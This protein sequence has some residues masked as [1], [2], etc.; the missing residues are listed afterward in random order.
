MLRLVAQPR[1][2]KRVTD[3]GTSM[4]FHYL[5]DN[6][7]DLARAVSLTIPASLIVPDAQ[8]MLGRGGV[9]AVLGAIYDR[10]LAH[11][12]H[13]ALDPV[14]ING[15]PGQ[16]VRSVAEVL[17]YQ[18]G[19]CLDLALLFAS[20]CLAHPLVPVVILFRAT[21]A[22]PAHA[23]LAVAAFEYGPRGYRRQPGATLFT[24]GYL[25]RAEALDDLLSAGYELLEPTGVTPGSGDV[26]SAGAG[27]GTTQRRLS[28]AEAFIA[29]QAHLH[30]PRPFRCALDIRTLCREGYGPNPLVESTIPVHLD[31]SAL[32]EQDLD[33][34]HDLLVRSYSADE[35]RRLCRYHFR[36]VMAN[37]GS[38][39]SPNGIAEQ[40]ILYC[41]AQ[42]QISRLLARVA[43]DNPAQWARYQSRHGT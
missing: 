24:R 10:V 7:R 27:I 43:A 13:Y 15:E 20:V 32:D 34:I 16:P 25:E 42:R 17:T 30:G 6:P 36:P 21:S 11:Q 37:L 4:R 9:R 1:V 38:D 26:A 39:A 23:I 5:D 35:L 12:L 31:S 19:T 28:A 33:A 29:G 2:A 22:L 41:D 14:S 8:E 40:L 18:H 3:R